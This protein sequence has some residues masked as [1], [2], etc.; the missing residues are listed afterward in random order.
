MILLA[1]SKN[2]KYR[3]DLDPTQKWMYKTTTKRATKTED[4]CPFQFSII[5]LR[6]DHP[7]RPGRWLLLEPPHARKE[8]CQ[9]H[10]H[11]Y[12]FSVEEMHV[13]ISLMSAEEKKLAKNC[14]Q[15][16]LPS[17]MAASLL[18]LQRETNL[19][20][21][22]GQLDYLSRAERAALHGLKKDASTADKLQAVFNK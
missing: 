2:S 18:T 21:K 7:S 6:D 1:C 11:H 3:D 9:L 13:P 4:Q 8:T 12:H 20:W 14:S 10:K 16:Y 17:S 19:K 22:T 15:L 5:L